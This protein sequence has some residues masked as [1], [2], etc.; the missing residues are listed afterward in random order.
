MKLFALGV[1][2]ALSLVLVSCSRRDD[3]DP[4]DSAG[5]TTT[6]SSTAQTTP[7]ASTTPAPLGATGPLEFEGSRALEHVRVLAEEIGP[8]VSGTDAERQT[9]DY[10]SAQLRSYGYDVEV[11]EFSF[12]GDRFNRIGSVREGDAS[13]EALALVGSAS[14][15]LEGAAVFVG[16]ADDAGIAGK[17]L[18]GKV[19]VAMRGTIPFAD[20]YEKAKAAGA[21]ALVIINNAPGPVSGDLRREATIPVVAVPGEAEG[22]LKAAATAGATVSVDAPGGDSTE[23]L[24]VIAR[25]TSDAACTVLV[26]G[27]H[28]TVPA[29]PGANDNA[30][31]TAAIV[32]LAR[33]FAAD[34]TLDAGLCFATFGAEESG[35]YG[36]AALAS[37]LKDE[38]RLPKYMVN[39]DVAGIGRGVSVTATTGLGQRVLGH[40][41]ELGIQARVSE[42]PA[43]TGSDHASFREV[44]V[45]VVFIW[46]DGDF[47]IHTPEDAFGLIELDELERVGD[48]NQ[49]V[50]ADFVAEVARG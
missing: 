11:M 13:F 50:I 29:A 34:G 26:G 16:L 12:S 36:S 1:A 20:K 28:D 2:L 49:R 14:G 32:E 4:A 9:A 22:R 5:T 6:P 37:R 24:N 31:G 27:H 23:A 17:D 47:P 41:S 46:S 25:P 21:S 43:N 15:K 33:A 38:G 39:I 48:L 42:L 45:P 40:A 44:G 35:L 8:R 18:K 10:L 7:P 30:S 3:D 19:A